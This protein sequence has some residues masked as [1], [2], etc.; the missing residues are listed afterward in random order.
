MRLS[1][2]ADSISY[3]W[4][5]EFSKEQPLAPTPGMQATL[6]YRPLSLCLRVE[7]AM[8]DTDVAIA[9]MAAMQAGCRVQ[10]SAAAARPW[11]VTFA[12]QYNVPLTV[13]SRSAFEADFHALAAAGVTVR[14]PAAQ[15]DT[16][17]RAAEAGLPLITQSVLANGRL[18]LLNV[19]CT[20]Y[21]VLWINNGGLRPR[22]V[23]ATGGMC[24][25]TPARV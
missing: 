16:L 17:A 9:L 2:A 13:E 10:I 12:E 15:E 6:S 1:A 11:V 14:D 23:A 5:E 7:K 21:Y 8:A 19:L 22:S 18:E 3:W 24:V 20:M 4:E 25:S